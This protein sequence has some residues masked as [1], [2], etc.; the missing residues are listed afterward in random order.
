MM[1]RRDFLKTCC[2]A[3]IGVVTPLGFTAPAVTSSLFGADVIANCH[4]SCIDASPRLRPLMIEGEPYYIML[5][6]PKQISALKTMIARD[7]YKHDQWA[8]RYDRW[9]ASPVEA[10]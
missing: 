6:H 10:A 2:I 3:G 7:K 9:L 5:T 4:R 8:K 1:N